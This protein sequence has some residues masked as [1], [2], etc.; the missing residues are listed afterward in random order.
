MNTQKLGLGCLPII[1]A[2]AVGTERTGAAVDRFEFLDRGG[3]GGGSGS[4]EF[5]VHFRRVR[6][7]LDDRPVGRN[8]LGRLLGGLEPRLGCPRTRSRPLGGFER[9][10]GRDRSKKG[11]RFVGGLGNL[12]AY[13]LAGCLLDVADRPGTGWAVI[14]HMGAVDEVGIGREDLVASM[15][16]HAV[17][18]VALAHMSAV[19]TW[20]I[21]ALTVARLEDADAE[22]DGPDGIVCLADGNVAFGAVHVPLVG[23][24]LVVGAAFELAACASPSEY[25]LVICLRQTKERVH[26]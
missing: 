16:G 17:A 4:G 24:V 22:V 20:R 9:R 23:A 19:V 10:P 25:V 12:L 2:S 6:P 14:E 15:V 18:F 3:S 8:A 21:V 5:R 13:A 26:P 11:R 1:T 7:T